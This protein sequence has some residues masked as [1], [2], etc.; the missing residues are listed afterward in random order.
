MKCK[1]CDNK[2]FVP[3]NGTPGR[4]YCEHPEIRENYEF[5]PSRMICRTGRRDKELTVKTAPRWC[6]M[7][8]KEKAN[9]KTDT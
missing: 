2:K 4:Y 6:P 7:N 9:G 5:S 1:D 8:R 3:R